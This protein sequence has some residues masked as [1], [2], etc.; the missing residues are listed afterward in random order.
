MGALDHEV[1]DHG[2]LIMTGSSPH[3]H[4]TP[5]P[6]PGG[7]LWADMTEPP[8]PGCGAWYRGLGGG[9]GG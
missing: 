4:G 7:H 9:G 5:S 1:H 2:S 3:P 6:V 8:V